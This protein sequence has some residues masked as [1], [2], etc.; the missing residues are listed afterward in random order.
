MTNNTVF[1]VKTDHKLEFNDLFKK[2]IQ[3]L[4]DKDRVDSVFFQC[5]CKKTDIVHNA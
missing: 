3:I 4:E 1:F 5:L 2:K